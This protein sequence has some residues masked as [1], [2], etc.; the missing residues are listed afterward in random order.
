MSSLHGKLEEYLAVRKAMGFKMERH[1][2]LLGQYIGFL[3]AGGETVVTI[4]NA[5]A[6]AV[7]PADARTRWHALR[8]SMVRG[9]AAWLNAA[10]PAHQVPPGG[11]IPY[12][13]RGIVPYLY[14]DEEITALVREAGRLSGRLRAATFQTLVRLLAVTGMRVGEAIRLDRGDYDAAAGVL[15]VRDTKFGKSRHLPLHP[16][17]VTGL[18]E[19]LR[20]RDETMPA[21]PSPALLLTARGC[22][23]RYERTWETFHALTVS[24]GLKPRSTACRPRIHDLRHSMAVA[25]LLAWHR[26]G[27]DVQ[28]M[29]PRLSAYLGHADPRHTY[30]Y[31]SAAPEL[32]ALAAARL[33]ASQEEETP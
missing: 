11:M 33:Q 8:L 10:D 31:M 13:G 27:A 9:F 21:P 20:L 18:N 12:G 7:L 19:Y 1:E 2:K 3:D 26:S 6:W 23:L 25:T 32:L 14:T 5:V 16:T 29:M 17:A 24:A 22:R 28:A 4:E 15:T 30:S